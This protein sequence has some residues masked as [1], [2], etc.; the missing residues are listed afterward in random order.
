MVYSLYSKWWSILYFGKIVDWFSLGSVGG[1]GAFPSY[2]WFHIFRTND[3]VLLN[4]VAS[5]KSLALFPTLIWLIFNGSP[6]NILR[7][8]AL[9]I[10]GRLT[11][12]HPSNYCTSHGWNRCKHVFSCIYFCLANWTGNSLYTLNTW[13]QKDTATVISTMLLVSGITTILH[14][15]FGTRLPLVQGSSFVYLAPALVIINAQEYRNLTEHVSV[16]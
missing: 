7:S 9:L 1:Q 13:S 3:L 10:I 16:L 8:A 12:I 6:T 4:L 15:Y 2:Y 14:S 5:H 11:D